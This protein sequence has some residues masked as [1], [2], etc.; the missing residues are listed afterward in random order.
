MSGVSATCALGEGG[1]G[2]DKLDGGR[3]F[4]VVQGGGGAD[5]VAGGDEGLTE[6]PPFGF[7]ETLCGNGGPDVLEGDTADA[8][9]PSDDLI[10]GG[11]GDDTLYGRGGHDRLWGRA[12]VD[13]LFGGAEG[14][15]LIGGTSSDALIG[16]LG[17]DLLIGDDGS[18]GGDHDHAASP[19]SRDASVN[20]TELGGAEGA[21]SC[22][23]DATIAGNGTINID[24]DDSTADNGWFEGVPI[25]AGSFDLDHN[26][27][28]D[29]DDTGFLGDLVIVEGKVDGTTGR[30]DGVSLQREAG[31]HDA[32]C[33]FGGFGD[34]GIYG[35]DGADDLY[36]D[37]G[38][39]LMHGNAGGDFMRGGQDSDEMYG[40]DGED[41]MYGDSGSDDM[42]GDADNDTMRGG[43]DGDA[44]EG[45]G[46]DDSMWGEAG[47]DRMIGG[48][49]IEAP[50]GSD[51]MRGGSGADVMT[52]DNAIISAT[53]LVELLDIPW[54]DQAAPDATH[55][56]P[57]FM[58]GGDD[59]DRM[60][61]QG[62]NDEMFGAGGDDVVAG[63]AGSDYIEG[64]AD[65]DDLTGG[66][67]R[68]WDFATSAYVEMAG[69]NDDAVADID[70][71]D[72]D[73]DVAELVGDFIFG[74]DGF[75]TISG[76][77]AVAMKIAGSP[78]PD[79][80]VPRSIKLLDVEL[81]GST[82]ASATSG[83][84]FL[85]GEGDA[86]DMFGQGDNDTMFGGA[87][88]DYLEGNHDDDYLQGDGGSDDLIGGGSAN[89]GE[90]G[91]DSIGDGMLD[92][93][94]IL[95]GDNGDPSTTGPDEAADVLTGD[96][97]RTTR[98][99]DGSAWAMDPN[100]GGYV[101]RTVQLFDVD[102]V[103]DPVDASTSAGDQLFG[104]D[105]RDLLFGQGNGSHVQDP[106]GLPLA[107][108]DPTTFA[109]DVL[110][111]GNGPDYAEGN[112]GSDLVFGEAG[113][114]DL[115]GGSSDQNGLI[116]AGAFPTDLTD[117][118]DAVFG[119][120]EDDQILGDNG[121]VTRLVDGA[122]VWLRL[123]GGS[124][125][126]FDF[127]LRDAVTTMVPEVGWGLR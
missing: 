111:G 29:T 104:E 65:D 1:S 78:D 117:S 76:D 58:D 21:V 40:D 82:I 103:S 12:D 44:M 25:I 57:D 122:G 5:Q 34:D 27:V 84:D 35:V 60:Y 88:D 69:V 32:D 79:G 31:V 90:I 19:Q 18:A 110:Y 121:I 36:G 38:D 126:A 55:S 124:P 20:L 97:A 115:I 105:G 13:L 43:L 70:D 4:D 42:F 8:A 114:D 96:N 95:W 67:S 108:I 91:P 30:V 26:G 63:N 109:G 17:S 14:D 127:A 119:G 52:G 123:T 48:S 22:Q 54:V 41:V 15:D 71:W 72:N 75:D 24:G 16:G 7:S 68:Y 6:V 113:E 112:H 59:L 39:D 99:V 37:A 50:D 118:H 83:N 64:G 46:G 10:D 125:I 49:S 102:R 11:D 89:N 120:D 81:V 66:S 94:D 100:D 47:A 106:G 93:S 101:A 107:D 80:A 3:G 9:Y 33:A 98:S 23:L 85:F 2:N 77:N 116:G 51:T 74:G 92:G 61:G 87:D 86:D 62:G 53:R 56:A 28:I 45:N 73:T